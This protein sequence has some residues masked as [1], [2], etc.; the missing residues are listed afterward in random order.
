MLLINYFKGERTPFIKWTWI[1]IY[2]H[3]VITFQKALMESFMKP[4]KHLEQLLENSAKI[5]FSHVLIDW[6]ES[7]INPKIFSIKQESNTNQNKQKLFL[8]ISIDR[9]EVS[10]NLKSWNLNSHFIHFTMNT[11]QSYIIITTYPYIHLYIQ[12]SSIRL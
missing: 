7:S 10:T 11:L 4:F 12:Q 9:I 5:Q 2:T 6:K 3:R 8:I 1:T